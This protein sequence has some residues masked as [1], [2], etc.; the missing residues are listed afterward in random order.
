M[1]T[2]HLK[3]LNGPQHLPN[4]VEL[5]AGRFI[6]TAPDIIKDMHNN[7]ISLMNV[8]SDSDLKFEDIMDS[9]SDFV[10]LE[11]GYNVERLKSQTVEKH[12]GQAVLS[13]DDGIEITPNFY[14]MDPAQALAY[15]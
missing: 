11:V 3:N 4:V 7:W 10:D 2:E 1:I 8:S 15:S 12:F 13:S 6:D 14:F 9:M 5:K